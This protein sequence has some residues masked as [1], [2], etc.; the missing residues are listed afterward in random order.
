[1]SDAECVM[2]PPT[3]VYRNLLINLNHSLLFVG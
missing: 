3:F 2:D 1:M